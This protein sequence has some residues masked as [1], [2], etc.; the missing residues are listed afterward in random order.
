[1]RFYPKR[2]VVFALALGTF[3][4]SL[5]TLHFRLQKTRSVGNDP[6]KD[7]LVHNEVDGGLGKLPPVPDVNQV[8][9][10]KQPVL[11]KPN[12]PNDSQQVGLGNGDQKLGEG[13]VGV[14]IKMPLR[15][16]TTCPDLTQPADFPETQT[17]Q[18]YR[19]GAMYVFAAYLDDRHNIVRITAIARSLQTGFCQMWY[20]DGDVMKTSAVKSQRLPE[21]HGR[22]YDGFYVTCPLPGGRIPYAVSVVSSPCEKPTNV[23]K[24]LNTKKVDYSKMTGFGVCSPPFNF[25]YKRV[26]QM[27]ENLETNRMLG[28][29]KFTFY[30]YSLGDEVYKVLKPYIQQ[31]I[32]ELVQWPIPVLVQTWP[33]TVTQE[34]HYFGQI[35]N[36]NDCLYRNHQKVKYVAFTD[37]DEYAVPRRQKNWTALINDLEKRGVHAASYMFRN[38]F[39]KCEWDDDEDLAKI[40]LIKKLN[41]EV[42]LKTKRQPRIFSPNQRSKNIVEV[43]RAVTVGVHNIWNFEHGFGS[44][45]LSESDGLLHHYRNW[46]TKGDRNYVVDKYMHKFRTELLGR[47]EKVKKDLGLL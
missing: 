15:K 23:L 30:N 19:N 11:A 7:L 2:I 44:H 45:I 22:K 25:K 21:G 29:T 12:I 34:I 8:S 5:Y 17:F 37:L 47:V 28:A 16:S 42:I 36:L 35:A 27:I 10:R 20:R 43:R 32:V 14:A 18:P 1:M 4:L 33:P 9:Q 46:E 38:V 6:G 26:D 24:V 41:M 31:G 40:P 39:F 3:F 13:V